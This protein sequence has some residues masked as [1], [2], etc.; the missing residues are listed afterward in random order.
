MKFQ[1]KFKYSGRIAEDDVHHSVT[2]H[3]KNGY[4]I[5]PIYVEVP[6]G[7]K[8]PQYSPTVYGTSTKYDP[9]NNCDGNFMSAKFQT[10][11]NC[12]N[13]GTNVATNSYAQPG[14]MTGKPLPDDFT[15]EDVVKG[16]ES[17][18]L[19]RIPSDA[20][21]I[22]WLSEWLLQHPD[23]PGHLVALMISPAETELG[24]SGDYHWARCDNTWSAVI[25][26]QP[27]QW[28][29]KNSHDQITNFD[30]VGNPITD[31]EIANWTV[32]E[33]RI[34]PQSDCDVVIE[35]KF[36]A[37]MFVPDNTKINII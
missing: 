19:I 5:A 27:M 23:K 11:N 10:N 14:R 37:Y 33:G 4:T 16:A 7:D 30:F 21:L 17:D 3:A 31:P 22:L 15:G 8:V 24:W 1:P 13:Y 2:L 6:V 29:Q 25:H 32:N 35:Y 20:D 28:S 36:F 18:G 34:K 12:Y 26:K 9:P